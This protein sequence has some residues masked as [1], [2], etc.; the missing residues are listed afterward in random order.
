MPIPRSAASNEQ[1]VDLGLRADVD[2]ARRLVEHQHLRARSRATSPSTTFCWLPPESVETGDARRVRVDRAARRSAARD[3]R[4]PR[5]R[6][7][8]CGAGRCARSRPSSGSRARSSA[9]RAPGACGRPGRRRRRRRIGV[10]RPAV[11]RPGGPRPRSCPCALVQAEDRLEQLAAARA[12]EP[13]KADDLAGRDVE[14]RS[15]SKHA[16]RVERSRTR[17]TGLGRPRSRRRASRRS[18]VE[19]AADHQ[20]DQPRAV[21]LGR[22]GPPP[23]VCPSRSTVIRSASSKISLSRC[24]TKIIATPSRAQ[25]ADEPRRAPRPRRR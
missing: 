15:S 8:A 21:E 22:P 20:L 2:A 18:L 1:P 19:L 9:A 14:R 5:G 17:S 16:R 6:C 11:A 25:A 12:D 23:T 4:A 7:A 3:R 10:L 24:E 13:G